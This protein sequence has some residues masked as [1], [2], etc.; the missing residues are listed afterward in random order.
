[1]SD[2]QS[3]SS[4][5]LGTHALDTQSVPNMVSYIADDGSFNGVAFEGITSDY[6]SVADTEVGDGPDSVTWECVPDDEPEE[7]EVS[8]PV[9]QFAQ[10]LRKAKAWDK[11]ADNGCPTCGHDV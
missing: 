1:M 4:I 3:P 8:L 6:N 10:L 2:A 9:S 7:A 5:P 11:L